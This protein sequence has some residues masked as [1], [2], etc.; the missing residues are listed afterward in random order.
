[1]IINA[2]RMM[3]LA[4]GEIRRVNP[5]QRENLAEMKKLLGDHA[6]LDH[7]MRPTVPISLSY[8]EA[9]AAGMHVYSI[10]SGRGS[11]RFFEIPL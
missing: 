9:A 11:S 2:V 7:L 10:E 1:M 6:R 5:A 8:N 3:I 4:R